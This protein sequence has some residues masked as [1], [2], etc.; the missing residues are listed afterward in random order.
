MTIFP[1][2]KGSEQRM[3]N[4]T[5]YGWFAPTSYSQPTPPPN[6]PPSE[7]KGLIRLLTIDFPYIIR[8]AIVNRDYNLYMFSTR[9]PIGGQTSNSK[10]R[11][12]IQFS[13]PK[14]APTSC[15]DFF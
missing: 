1:D 11:K 10:N 9:V 5:V 6:V 15:W 7:T 3:K 8:P 12:K 13:F 2:P 14:L 4:N